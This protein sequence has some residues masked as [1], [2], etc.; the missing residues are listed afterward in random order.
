LWGLYS[1]IAIIFLPKIYYSFAG[2]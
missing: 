1:S 2:K